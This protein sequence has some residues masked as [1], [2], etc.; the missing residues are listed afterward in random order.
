M[1]RHRT[2]TVREEENHKFQLAT[3]EYLHALVSLI[4]ELSRLA[5]NSVTLGAYDPTVA[6]TMLSD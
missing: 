6:T 3:E 2:I 4:N 5:V 1:L